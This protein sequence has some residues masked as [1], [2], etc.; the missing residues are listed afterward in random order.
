MTKRLF[1]LLMVIFTVICVSSCANG[2]KT[3]TESDTADPYEIAQTENEAPVRGGILNLCIYEVDSL[4]PLTTQNESNLDV[5]RLMFDGLF[6]VN[7][8]YSVENSLCESY[9]VS[10]DGLK[11]SF[12]IKNDIKFHDGTPLSAKDVDASFALLK[13]A[14]VPYAY[15]FSAVES[16]SA[17]QTTW[18][19][20]LTEPVINFPALLDF[21]ILPSKDAHT[22]NNI[23]DITYI[24]NGTGLYKVYDYK[25]TKELYLS[26]NENHFSGNLP[27]IPEI[28]VYLVS[29]KETAISLF[30][31][32]YVDILPD[33][34]VNLDEYTPK[35]HKTKSVAFPKNSFTFLGLNN[36][37]P[38][39]LSAKVRTAIATAIDKNAIVNDS[40]THISVA[41]DIPINKYSVY[42]NK[43]IEPVVF[44]KNK[45]AELLKEDGFAKKEGSNILEKTI[46]DEVNTTSVDILVNSENPLRLKIAEHIKASLEP[47]GFYVTISSVDFDTYKE[48]IENKEYDMFI[49]HINI[50]QNNDLSFML[51]TDKNMFGYSSS[52][53]DLCLSQLKVMSNQTAISGAFSDLCTYLAE[54]MPIIGLYYD[55]GTLLCAKEIKGNMN[56][57]ESNVF[58]NI[59]EWFI[60]E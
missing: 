44:D 20:T 60:G 33:S 22:E 31:N 45:A 42:Y 51:Q 7:S 30:E 37:K 40:R 4:N 52:K 38:I 6:K 10:E 2:S 14:S 49:G 25:E 17:T 27:H 53:I 34:T 56:P 39:L 43:N 36:Q 46:Y 26:I 48:R 57:A 13:E 59:H 58:I 5:L 3:E 41:A 54:D 55:N 29:D 18:D 28:K 21:P 11:Y 9:T 19:V 50:A 47:I 32:L 16:T 23:T 12:K 35:R 8:D 15:R 24:P 1:S